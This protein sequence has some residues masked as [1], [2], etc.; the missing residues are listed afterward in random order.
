MLL[1]LLLLCWVV[2]LSVLH[3]KVIAV[4]KVVL[5]GEERKGEGGEEREG[6]GERR[7]GRGGEGK[8]GGGGT[9]VQ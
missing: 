3:Q 1:W 2:H 6:E 9:I 7:R 5:C 4:N 8:G